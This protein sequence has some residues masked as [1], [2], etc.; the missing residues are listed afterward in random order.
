MASGSAE[1]LFSQLVCLQLLSR[2]DDYRNDDAGP[3]WEGVGFQ[4]GFG[5]LYS[6]DFRFDQRLQKLEV[7][8]SRLNQMLEY[9]VARLD[10]VMPPRPAA[11]VPVPTHA[12]PQN[13]PCCAPCP[14]SVMPPHSAACVPVPTYAG[15][16]VPSFDPSCAPSLTPSS[17]VVSPPEPVSPLKYAFTCPLCT[18]PQY[19]PKAHCEHMRKVGLGGGICVIKSNVDLHRDIIKVFLTP[20]AFSKW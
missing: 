13:G 17:P 11:S 7:G 10:A 3:C 20:A 14:S 5:E 18:K 16:G 15:L 4:Q 2:M 12:G 6:D 1:R 9:I 19:T 8:Q